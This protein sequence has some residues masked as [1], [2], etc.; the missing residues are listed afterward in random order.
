GVFTV[1][2]SFAISYF[3]LRNKDNKSEEVS[4]ISKEEKKAQLE[5]EL[6]SIYEDTGDYVA[7]NSSKD[8][9][10][11]FKLPEVIENFAKTKSKYIYYV[12]GTL[13]VDDT[14]NEFYV[15]TNQEVYRYDFDKIL[16]FEY[17]EDGETIISG[18]G[19]ATVAGGMAFGLLGAMAGASGKRK[20]TRK[21][22]SQCVKI[23]IN[24]LINPTL[25]LKLNINNRKANSPQYKFA[26][27]QA[28]EIIG[29]FSYMKENADK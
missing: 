14:N 9:P 24:D 3:L 11:K 28:D 16:D 22:S 2:L 23:I 19:M 21:V 26:I 15:F 10:S 25:N 6:Q 27:E 5:Q 17:I 18:K 13:I 7:K 20:E 29:A 12:N 4:T 8:L 1:L